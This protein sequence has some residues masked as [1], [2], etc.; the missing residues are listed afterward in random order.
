MC[1]ESQVPALPP[2]CPA[3]LRCR[4]AENSRV[5]L[6][7]HLGLPGFRGLKS[8]TEPCVTLVSQGR[9]GSLQGKFTPLSLWASLVLPHA[10]SST[11]GTACPVPRCSEHKPPIS[12]AARARRGVPLPRLPHGGAQHPAPQAPMASKQRQNVS[13]L[14]CPPCSESATRPSPPPRHR[15]ASSAEQRCRCAHNTSR[16]TEI[17]EENPRQLSQTST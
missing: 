7:T 17:S 3:L 11:A 4:Q 10:P 9:T 2:P 16:N 6:K 14:S 12:H 1:E 13:H 15:A 8:C 5:W